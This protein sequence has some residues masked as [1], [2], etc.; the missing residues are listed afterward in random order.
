MRRHGY[1]THGKDIETA[2]YRAVYTK[3]NAGVQTNA[4]LLRS[5]L[6]P[7]I[8][9]KFELVPLTG[10]M[11]HGCLKMNEGTPGKLWKLWAAEVEKLSL[12]I[13]RG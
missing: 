6:P 2:V 1:T 10:D 12:Y 5:A 7:G 3:V 13:N 9:A 11:C 4:M 8:E